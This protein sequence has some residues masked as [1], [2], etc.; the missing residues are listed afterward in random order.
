MNLLVFFF[1]YSLPSTSTASI[2]TRTVYQDGIPA[3]VVSPAALSLLIALNL[4]WAAVVI[5]GRRTRQASRPNAQHTH[6][7]I[8]QHMRA[9]QSR[10]EPA[11]SVRGKVTGIDASDDALHLAE[12]V[13][14]INQ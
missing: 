5:S 8:T 1:N 7:R 3:Q 9:R 4:T 10:L 6:D 12:L 13:R 2:Q 11:R 14:C